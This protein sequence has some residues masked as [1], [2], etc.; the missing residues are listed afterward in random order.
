[1]KKLFSIKII[2]LAVAVVLLM[3]PAASANVGMKGDLGV[4]GHIVLGG[5]ANNYSAFTFGL[6]PYISIAP[7]DNLSIWAR[8]P[9]W[10]GNFDNV[11]CH[12]FPFVFGAR[13]YFNVMDRLRVYP[14][15]GIGAS[16]LHTSI[17]AFGVTAT[18][19]TGGF[20]IE[21]GGGVEY[22]VMDNLAIDGSLDFFVPKVEDGAFM[23]IGVMV[24]VIYYLPVF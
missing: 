16:V 18:D 20:S 19:S 5:T 24:G 21:F 14:S 10:E 8:L 6:T 23:R 9:F 22:E 13:Y 4:G 1:M 2:I 12:V 17:S 11:D 15:L 7:M 3:A